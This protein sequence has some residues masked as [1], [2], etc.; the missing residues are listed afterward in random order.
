GLSCTTPTAA[1]L[2]R[3]I[4]AASPM[5]LV[6]NPVSVSQD[7]ALAINVPSSSSVPVGLS[8]ETYWTSPGETCSSPVP[9]TSLKLP[10]PRSSTLPMMCNC[11]ASV[12]TVS[13]VQLGH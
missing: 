11:C 10:L 5:P 4:T 9:P 2:S 8:Y 13:V 3:P 6:A 12:E 1:E 7:S